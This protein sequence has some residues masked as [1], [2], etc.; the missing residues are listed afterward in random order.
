MKNS[1]LY[2]KIFGLLYLQPL[3]IYRLLV[4]PYFTENDKIFRLIQDLYV[5]SSASSTK[6]LTYQMNI[7]LMLLK[8][9]KIALVDHDLSGP[10]FDLF[11]IKML[12]LLY[13]WNPVVADYYS[14]LKRELL[15]LLLDFYLGSQHDG[16]P[17]SPRSEKFTRQPRLAESHGRLSS[18]NLQTLDLRPVGNGPSAGQKTQVLRRIC[19]MIVLLGSSCSKLLNKILKESIL[20]LKR[21]RS[22]SSI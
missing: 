1:G 5:K 16:S 4:S 22:L 3:Y 10:V 14:G 21:F 8:H 2:E 7:C 20:I 11:S 13:S 17:H 12:L 19:V 18:A 9:E 15:K 6:N